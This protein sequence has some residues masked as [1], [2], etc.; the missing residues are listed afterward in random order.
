MMQRKMKYNNRKEYFQQYY[1]ANKERLDRY[2]QQYR[3]IHRHQI[4]ERYRRYCQEAK[5]SVLTHYGGGKLA[6]V[7]CGFD[8][9]D[10]LTIDHIDSGG[11]A[12]RRKL[13]YQN[14]Y[15]WLKKQ[16]YPK[17]YQTLCANCQL[18]KR[19]KKEMVNLGKE[20]KENAR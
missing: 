6:C 19:L 16:G 2:A 7:Q 8:D 17:G 14:F 3:H 11:T 13:G 12:H 20:A 9:V 15:L 5:T 10:A 4:R 18:I 1:Q